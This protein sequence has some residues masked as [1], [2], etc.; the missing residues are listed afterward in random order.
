[1][2]K[3]L[4]STKL[5]YANVIATLALFLALGGGGAWAATTVAGNS[6]GTAQLKNRAVT[7]KKV[8]YGTLLAKDFKRGQLPTAGPTGPMGPAGPQGALGPKGSAGEP[9]ERGPRGAKGDTGEAGPGGLK[10]E[11]GEPGET[12]PRGPK[13]E[14]GEQGEEGPRGARGQIGPEGEAGERGETGK[15]GAVGPQGEPGEPGPE[16]EAGITR[17][18]TRYGPEASALRGAVSYATCNTKQ[19]VVTGGGYAFTSPTK[20]TAYTVTL[21]RSSRTE[22]I[23]EEEIEEREEEGEVVEETE[24]EEFFVFPAPKDGSTAATGWAV[25]M[26]AVGGKLIN[27]TFRAYV[28]CAE[29]SS[30]AGSRQLS[31]AGTN[32]LSQAN[33]EPQQVLELLH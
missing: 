33:E 26:E 16:G 21:D 20:G 9:G 5:T 32:E 23:S 12:G 31:Q 4:S 14:T 19:E 2:K 30:P 15:R 22:A 28:E 11:P 3:L 10:G 27:A 1:M 8:S 18:V 17:T 13:G 7:A 29:M 25:G 6:I 24:G